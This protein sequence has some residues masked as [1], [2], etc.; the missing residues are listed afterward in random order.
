M[1]GAGIYALIRPSLMVFLIETAV[2]VLIL[3]WNL[4]IE[5][6][7][8]LTFGVFD[9]LYL[10]FPILVVF[11]FIGHYL[12]LQHVREQIL[13]VEPE[14]IRAAKQI[15]KSL[16]KL[17]LKNEPL[18]LQTSDSKCR[19]QLMGDEAFFIQR[20]LLKAFVAPKEAI[21]NSIMK[22]FAKRLA[23]NFKHPLGKLKY[24]FDKKN[25]E[26]LIIWLAE[27]TEQTSDVLSDAEKGISPL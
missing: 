9:L 24:V 18:V 12:K 22:L 14:Q 17:K 1:L 21:R 3:L 13:S 6:Y 26:K 5:I 7:N 2:T 16:L 10:I 23:V 11:Y 15:C 19:V 8:Y 20:D 4:A 25:S 27:S